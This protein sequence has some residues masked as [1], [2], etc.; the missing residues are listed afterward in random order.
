MRLKDDK[1]PARLTFFHFSPDTDSRTEEKDK[2]EWLQ[3]TVVGGINSTEDKD[4]K[5]KI[6]RLNENEQFELAVMLHEKFK[7]RI[8]RKGE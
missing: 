7:H 6:M 2:Q 4:L 5:R 8:G 3:I 1:L